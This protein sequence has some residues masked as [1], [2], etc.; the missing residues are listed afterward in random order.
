MFPSLYLIIKALRFLPVSR[1]FY[2]FALPLKSI[3]RHYK[4]PLPILVQ[5]GPGK[6]H[7]DGPAQSIVGQIQRGARVYKSVRTGDK[8][9]LDLFQSVVAASICSNPSSPPPCR[10]GLS[11]AIVGWSQT[12]MDKPR[13]SKIML[14]Q[15]IK[16]SHSGRRSVIVQTSDSLAPAIASAD[17]VPRGQPEQGQSAQGVSAGRGGTTPLILQ[18]ERSTPSRPTTRRYTSRWRAR[19]LLTLM[20]GLRPCTGARRSL[21]PTPPTAPIACGTPALL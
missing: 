7:P 17:H 10:L 20:D 18:D 4:S 13:I 19:V 8:Q 3:L 12:L 1:V 14:L 11:A 21:T 2:R 6:R 16:R 15:R 9:R 5:L